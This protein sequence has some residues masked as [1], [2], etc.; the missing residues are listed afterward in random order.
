MIFAQKLTKFHNFTICLPKKLSNYPN[1]YDICP[2]INKIPEFY[3]FC[4][5]KHQN[6]RIFMIFAPK[7]NRI[8]HDFSRQIFGIPK[9]L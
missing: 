4:P 2:K 1:F 3:D 9:F 8:L 6:R 5:K 7:I